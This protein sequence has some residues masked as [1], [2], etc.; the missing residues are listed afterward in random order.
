MVNRVVNKK[1]VDASKKKN[2]YFQ[3][4]I[5]LFSGFRN[6]WDSSFQPWESLKEEIS[7]STLYLHCMGSLWLPMKCCVMY[8]TLFGWRLSGDSLNF[9]SNLNVYFSCFKGTSLKWDCLRYCRIFWC[10]LIRSAPL[11]R[12]SSEFFHVSGALLL[13]RWVKLLLISFLS[14]RGKKNFSSW[15]PQCRA[16]SWSHAAVRMTAGL[17]VPSQNAAKY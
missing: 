1:R 11:R 2:H 14:S 7:K 17:F 4:V 12:N 8:W 5:R 9:V 6:F 10:R 15:K 13:S 3:S 16:N